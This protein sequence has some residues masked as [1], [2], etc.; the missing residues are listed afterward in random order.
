MSWEGIEPCTRKESNHIDTYKKGV[1]VAMDFDTQI[2]TKCTLGFSKTNG[3]PFSFF[4][5][6]QLSISILILATTSL[7][8]WFLVF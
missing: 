1:V 6:Q 3:T 8:A 4:L 5:H 7:W 2:I